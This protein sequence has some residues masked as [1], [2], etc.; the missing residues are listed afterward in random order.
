MI[1]SSR[2][3]VTRLFAEF[4]RKQFLAVKG[5]SVWLRDVAALQQIVAHQN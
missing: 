1:G 5:S 2:E 3:T 4:R